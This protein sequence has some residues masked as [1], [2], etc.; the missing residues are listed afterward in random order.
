MPACRVCPKR[1]LQTA[2]RGRQQ[3]VLQKCTRRPLPLLR[4]A[5]TRCGAQIDKL[6][7]RRSIRCSC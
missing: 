7:R 1:Q 4:A 6:D 5:A 2:K 3:T